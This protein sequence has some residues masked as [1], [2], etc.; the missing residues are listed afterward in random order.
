MVTILELRLLH[1]YLT[2]RKQRVKI[3]CTFSSWEDISFGV[4]QDSVL[5]PLLFNIFLCDPFL[6][7][8]DIDISS[9][10]DD[11]TSYAV[12]KNPEETIK[13]LENTSFD[14]LTWFK[15]N[16]M[17]ANDDKFHLLVNAKQ[18]MRAKIRPYDIQSREQQK[19][20]RVLID[21]KLPFDKHINNLCTKASHR[22]NALCRV[23]SSVIIKSG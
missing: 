2:N 5:G 19:L 21:N 7:I 13:V 12:G 8:N 1:N 10:A 22:L 9:Y 6:L 18:K 17:K 14:L 15:I 23:S 3:D 4:P 16:G 11:N 20:L